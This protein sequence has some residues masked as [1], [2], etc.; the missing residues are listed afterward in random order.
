LD[1]NSFTFIDLFSGIG[2]FHI[3]M[4]NLG[5]KC[6]FASEI[7]ASARQVYFDNFG[8]MPSG[9]ITK[10]DEKEIPKHDVL[11]AGFPCQSFS[12]AGNREGIS[13]PRGTLFFDIVRIAKHHKPKYLL[14]ENVR[15]LASH[16]NGNTWKVI[17]ANLDTIGY[18]CPDNPLIFS[19][20]YLVIPQFR[21]RV[22]ILCKRKDLG[23]V[24]PFNF[25]KSN[26][27]KSNIYGVLQNNTEIENLQKYQL[28]EEEISLIELWN[29]FFK[30]VRKELP[31]FPVWSEFLNENDVED[32]DE[33]P[34]WKQNFIIKNQNIYKKYAKQIDLWFAK[35][36]EHPCFTAQKQNLSGK[37]VKIQKAIFGI[38]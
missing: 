20:H 27:P 22:F 3:A 30:I 19:P 10:V 25:D 11:C 31:G 12:K 28:K 36:Q 26:I 18:N 35:A 5:G 24:E 38:R 37:Q 9:D 6:V 7:D 15:N 13:D 34:K 4:Q 2:G 14:L 1:L 16:D 8:L 21:E 17:R 29:D 23:T 32:F 33:L